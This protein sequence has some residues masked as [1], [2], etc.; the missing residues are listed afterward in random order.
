MRSILSPAAHN[1]L[2]GHCGL[3]I[4]YLNARGHILS[5]NP[6]W[7]EWKGSDNGDMANIEAILEHDAWAF[8][9]DEVPRKGFWEGEI[10]VQKAD[11]TE[12]VPCLAR[13]DL[14]PTEPSGEPAFVCVL[15]D[16]TARKL[17]EA[18]T[19]TLASVTAAL[20]FPLA[21]LTRTGQVIYRNRAYI[22]LVR[23]LD[24]PPLSQTRARRFYILSSRRRELL[25][26]TGHYSRGAVIRW[27][28][29]A[30]PQGDRCFVLGEEITEHVRLLEA[31]ETQARLL[32]KSIASL[33]ILFYNSVMENGE[34]TQL[35]WVGS[36]FE[37]LLGLP[38]DDAAQLENFSIN[39]HPVDLERCLKS[40]AQAGEN[41]LLWREI[42]RYRHPKTGEWRLHQTEAIP[43]NPTRS[44]VKWTGWIRDITEENEIKC[45]L[46]RAERM[47][48]LRTLSGGLAHEF[49]NILA[50]I[51]GWAEICM[52]QSPPPFIADGL[53]KIASQVGRGKDLVG[54]MS[55]LIRDDQEGAHLLDLKKFC[56]DLYELARA[57][58]PSAINLQLSL[59][60]YRCLA[61]A[62]ENQLQQAMLNLITNA[63]DVL[64]D[65][66]D[67]FLS[68]YCR[69]K[70]DEE[71]LPNQ[72]EI[73]LEVRDTG[74]GVSED[75]R[76]RVFD[77]LFTTKGERGS[78]IGLAMVRRIAREFGGR[79]E[80][81]SGEPGR[82]AVF[83]VCLPSV[84]TIE[85]SALSQKDE[86]VDQIP[87]GHP[88]SANGQW[89]T[90]KILLIEDNEELCNLQKGAFEVYGWRTLNAESVKAAFSL[91][92]REAPDLHA[93]LCDW[94]LPG[95][96]TM[97]LIRHF[98]ERAPNIPVIMLTGLLTGKRIEQLRAQGVS[99]ILKKPMSPYLVIEAVE[100]AIKERNGPPKTRDNA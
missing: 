3:P 18:S 68:L 41:Q 57:L 83:Q 54:R 50:I 45:Q 37:T 1:N 24:V 56:L 47:E 32:S 27:R 97:D 79:A 70:S 25:T 60:T 84:E 12:P 91:F 52:H 36:H 94:D 73:V 9:R 2:A 92:D 53:A 7:A 87:P 4:L 99:H 22:D 95:G 96:S 21:Q 75:L 80:C 15:H 28:Y 69:E 76:E 65:G 90:R 78:G 81:L 51:A 49:N 6:A 62:E 89:N 10:F 38:E 93:I 59:P 58:M 30:G 77:L 39:V 20:P 44:V 19:R 34:V 5:A 43:S 42:Y 71:A 46:D 14:A 8:I 61:V 86:D 88:P 23:R 16:I 29:W 26:F 98:R 11:S 63:R 82:G 72:Q 67:I 74:P 35:K 13:F 33:P 40:I 17:A 31:Q 48:T 64:P 66:G 85:P 100:D 55:G